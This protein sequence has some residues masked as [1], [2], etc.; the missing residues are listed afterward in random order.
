MFETKTPR[1]RKLAA[2]HQARYQSLTQC[3]VRT[4]GDGVAPGAGTPVSNDT[5]SRGTLEN[6][7]SDVSASVSVAFSA[8]GTTP[9]VKG[10]PSRG[11]AHNTATRPDGTSTGRSRLTERM[12]PKRV[13]LAS[14]TALFCAS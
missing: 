11:S 7:F 1:L 12:R 13:E 8:S 9:T 2:V 10:A 6:S 3:P 5:A 4:N 14:S